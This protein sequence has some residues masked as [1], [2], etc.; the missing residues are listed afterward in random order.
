MIAGFSLGNADNQ[1]PQIVAIAQIGKL[2]VPGALAEAL[3]GAEDDI[4]L[5][6]HP[7]RG[8]AELFTGQAHEPAVITLPEVGRG[9]L[10]API[11]GAPETH[12][13]GCGRL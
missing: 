11:Q 6:G 2:I 5:V 10:L 4:F 1:M 12:L 7:S 13:R 9:P 8:T 3:K